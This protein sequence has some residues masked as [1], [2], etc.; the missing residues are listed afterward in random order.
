M[1]ARRPALL[2]AVACLACLAAAGSAHALA[3]TPS[4]PLVIAT[5][6]DA[7]PVPGADAEPCFP[8]DTIRVE[9][10]ILAPREALL[11]RLEPIAGACLGTPLARAIV[12]Q[13]N[14]AHA[15]I[16]LVTTQ[17][18]LPE[19]D[20]VAT[21]ALVV[22]V[23]AGRI[24]AIVYEE[25]RGE[26]GLPL[27]ERLAAAGERIGASDGPWSLLQNLLGLLDVIDAPLDRFSLLPARVFPDLRRDLAFETGP[28][29]VL[30]IARIQEGLDAI[31][32]TPSA[33]AAA[34]LE[35]GG[36]PATSIVRIEN[37]PVDTFRL[38]VGYERNAAALTG[39]AR[40]VSERVRFDV[41]KDDL[42]GIGDS[43]RA[44]LA[45]GVNSNEVSAGLTLPF[46]RL[47]F[48]LDGAYSESFQAIT[49]FAGLFTQSGTVTGRASALVL[50]GEGFQTRAEGSLAWRANDRFVN[51]VALTPQRF[52]V[53]RLGLSHVQALGPAARASFGLG[54]SRGLT[55]LSATR[56]PPRPG[57]TLPRAQFLKLDANAGLFVRLSDHVRL[58]SD[59]SAQWAGTPLYADDQLSLSSASTIRGFS[60][61]PARVDRGAVVRSEL[62]ASLPVDALLGESRERLAFLADMLGGLEP[63]LFADMGSGRDLAAGR[64]VDRVSAGYGLRFAHGRARFDVVVAHPLH[65]HPAPRRARG[66]LSLT[67]SFKIF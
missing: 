42:V 7:E 44:A 17:G 11:A 26:A 15:E 33:R 39:G 60:D 24:D 3:Q 48:S 65:G 54:A 47:S 1:S 35:P 25:D 22:A 10:E 62:S 34:R 29:D 5:R 23:V 12:G 30:D 32:A 67:A 6:A 59:L 50:R 19:Q 21:R 31:N 55:W 28:G 40:T 9:G 27:S 52:T 13:V 61:L 36:E 45:S 51:D 2:R 63:Y 16:G 38:F 18:Y 20:I 57:P 49:P 66:E 64:G 37:A 8:V 46:R 4:E 53:G 41:A 14:E 58:R 56:D 43:W